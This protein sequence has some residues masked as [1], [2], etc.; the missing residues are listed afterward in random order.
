M[1]LNSFEIELPIPKIV[2]EEGGLETFRVVFI[3]SLAILEAGPS[4]EVLAEYTV[5]LNE[6]TNI[7][8]TIENTENQVFYRKRTTIHLT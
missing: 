1:Q 7:S 4:V 8:S 6:S 3:R 2:A 5:L